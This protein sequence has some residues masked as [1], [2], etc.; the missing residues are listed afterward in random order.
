M[1]DANRV[2]EGDMPTVV[3][4]GSTVV[5][6]DA[7]EAAGVVVAAGAGA[8]AGAVVEGVAVVVG[9][10]VVGASGVLAGTVVAVGSNDV[11]ATTVV[12]GN[13]GKGVAWSDAPPQAPMNPSTA[14][15]NANR[16]TSPILESLS[17]KARRAESSLCR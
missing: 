8:G 11:V 7:T 17:P 15:T 9:V 12:A 14:T 13:A 16:F 5:V 10:A 1:S 4:V 2:V 3:V 6:V